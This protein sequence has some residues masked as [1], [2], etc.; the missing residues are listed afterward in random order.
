MNKQGALD[1]INN[2]LRKALDDETVSTS[3]GADL[4]EE[5]V[6]DSLDGMVF[7]LELSSYT[8]KTFPETDLVE[9]GFYKVDKLIE[10]LT[11]P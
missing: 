7:I 3:P 5:E 6:L 11:T 1:A 8:D 4:V 10:F 9:L 2:A